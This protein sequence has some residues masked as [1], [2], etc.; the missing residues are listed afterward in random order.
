VIEKGE[1]IQ[2]TLPGS[3]FVMEGT[4]TMVHPDGE[5]VSADVSTPPDSGMP[6]V[7][8]VGVVFKEDGEPRKV[9]V[10][11]GFLHATYRTMT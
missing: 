2:V 9:F 11:R 1:K 3:A 7:F 6:E 10:S 5:T 8:Q 4:V